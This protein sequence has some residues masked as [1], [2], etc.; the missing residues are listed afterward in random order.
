MPTANV[1]VKLKTKINIKQLI[2][3]LL[4]DKILKIVNYLLIGQLV[5][6]RKKKKHQG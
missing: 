2:T 6:L 3:R 5:Y 4:E 1:R